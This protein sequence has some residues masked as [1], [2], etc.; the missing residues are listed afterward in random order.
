MPL[1]RVFCLGW[2]LILEPAVPVT[3][4]CMNL[5]FPQEKKTSSFPLFT[6]SGALVWKAVASVPLH[7]ETGNE[8]CDGTVE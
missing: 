1:V 5:K 4:S 3:N 8:Y 2:C 6:G 7:A